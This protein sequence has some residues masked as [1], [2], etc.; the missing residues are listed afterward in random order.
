[1]QLFNYP[2]C[3]LSSSLSLVPIPDPERPA[4]EPPAVEPARVPIKPR[5]QAVT[6]AGA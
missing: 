3:L 6:R 1:M 2:L 5:F 4:A